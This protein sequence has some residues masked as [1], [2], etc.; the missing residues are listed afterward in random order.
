[1]GLCR[2]PLKWMV[3]SD[4]PPTTAEPNF[5]TVMENRIKEIPKASEYL[6]DT[7]HGDNLTSQLY[8]IRKHH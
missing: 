5:D 2:P 4:T 6:I 1:M 8:Q 3:T 7:Y